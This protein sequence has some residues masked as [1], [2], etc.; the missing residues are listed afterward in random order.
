MR[1]RT[2]LWGHRRARLVSYVGID[3]HIGLRPGSY[4]ALFG[5]RYAEQGVHLLM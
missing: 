3:P 5:E 2:Y 1:A 4:G